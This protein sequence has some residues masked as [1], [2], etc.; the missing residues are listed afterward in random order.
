MKKKASILLL[1]LFLGSILYS[2]MEYYTMMAY[3]KEQQ[4]VASM[5]NLP[6][7]EFKI[8]KLNASLYTFVEDTE[9]EN[10]DE[11]IIIDHK[12]YHIFKKRIKDNVLQLYYLNNKNQSIIDVSLKK[13][14]DNQSF[15]NTPANSNKNPI[16]KLVK[17]FYKDYFSNTHREGIYLLEVKSNPELVFANRNQKLLAGHYI[18]NY[19][20]PKLG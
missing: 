15:T 6:N 16:Q 10:V 20:P 3:E 7:S 8:I 14:T 4:W 1:I 9:F 19:P 5:K 18:A 11:N 2:A 17:S 12:I 13:I